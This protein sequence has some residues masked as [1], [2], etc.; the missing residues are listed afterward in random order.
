MEFDEFFE[1]ALKTNAVA[2]DIKFDYADTVV[3]GIEN[4]YKDLPDIKAERKKEKE[5]L[6]KKLKDLQSK[7]KKIKNIKN[8]KMAEQNAKKAES[9]K[10]I[11]AEIESVKDKLHAIDMEEKGSEVTSGQLLNETLKNK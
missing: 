3:Q 1:E 9:R 6:T 5:A 8:Y 2:E 11:R 4:E 7:V 10:K